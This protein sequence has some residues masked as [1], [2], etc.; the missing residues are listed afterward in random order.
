MESTI[1]FRVT[2]VP[3]KSVLAIE[4]GPK[5]RCNVVIDS[6]PITEKPI[7]DIVNT[8]Y[9]ITEQKKKIIEQETKGE[10]SIDTGIYTKLEV[11]NAKI[12]FHANET[13]VEFND[14]KHVEKAYQNLLDNLNVTFTQN[15]PNQKLESF[16]VLL[17]IPFMQNEDDYSQVIQMHLASLKNLGFMHI[18][19][20]NQIGASFYSQKDRI[21]QENIRDNPIGLLINIGK[22][23]QIGIMDTKVLPEGFLDLSLGTT[24]VLNH[25]LAILRDLNILG[26]GQNT[27]VQWLISEGR[28]DGKAPLT[29]KTVRRK[30]FN[31]TPILNSP[32]ILFDYEAVTGMKNDPNSIVESIKRSIEAVKFDQ[33]KLEK[34]LKTIIITGPGAMFKGIDDKFKS[35]LQ[36]F[37]PKTEINVILGEEPLNTV[38]NGLLKYL[39]LW[40][41]LKVFDLTEAPPKEVKV[42]TSTQQSV[43]QQALDRLKIIKEYIGNLTELQIKAKE[44]Q[45]YLDTMPVGLKAFVNAH[46]TQESK[47]W[48]IEFN[49]F[50]NPLIKKAQEG[51]SQ[52]DE[53]AKE[54]T[55]IG[56]VIAKLP[57][58]IKPILSKVFSSYL[59]GLKMVRSVHLENVNQEYLKILSEATK[60][61]NSDPE[62]TL[63]QLVTET[64]LNKSLIVDLLDEYLNSFPNIGFINNKFIFLTEE[65]LNSLNTKL[66]LVK[67]KYFSS[68]NP[69]ATNLETRLVVI[70]IVKYYDFLIKG[71]QYLQQ[72]DLLDKSKKEKIEFESILTSKSSLL[73]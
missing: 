4:F 54:F 69:S 61:F 58:F 57:S 46:M 68:F 56:L 6:K 55:K 28:V 21:Q 45:Y 53:V 10:I 39:T 19:F 7:V 47:T 40:P 25:S 11:E 9:T 16:I 72:Q 51:L 14:P 18:T 42:E 38:T 41:K 30:E 60:T 62:F 32:R 17:S 36:H 37:Y 64:K 33:S 22:T 52:C 26:V 67:E 50:L 48:A 59:Q 63:D 12:L 23:S 71:Y 43:L 8:V 20:L 49:L 2:E 27:V 73:A 66:E 35:D 65:K 13:P 24:A 29:T 31:I 1:Q 44:F 3:T 5:L 34:L 15:N 70:Q